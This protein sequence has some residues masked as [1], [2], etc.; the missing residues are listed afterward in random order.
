VFHALTLL[1]FFS[2]SANGVV[3]EGRGEVVR[4][5]NLLKFPRPNSL[6]PGRREG[7]GGSAQLHPVI[8]GKIFCGCNK[9]E[10]E[11][12]GISAPDLAD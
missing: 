8:H 3:G 7:V 6:P 11:E 5:I 1:P 2:L 12:S 4:S 10:K 9:N